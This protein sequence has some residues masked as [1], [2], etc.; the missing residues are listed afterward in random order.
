[1]GTRLSAVILIP[2]TAAYLML[3]QPLGVTLFQ[4]RS[5]THDEAMQT[6]TVIAVAAI[7]LVPFAISQMQLFAFYAMPDTKTPA[8]INMPVAALRDRC[9]TSLFY[10]VLPYAL[11]DGRPDDGE[12]ASRTCSRSS[13]ATCCCAGG[14]ACSGSTDDGRGARPARRSQRVIAAVPTWLLVH[15]AVSTCSAPARSASAITLVVGG[16]A[17]DRRSTSSPRS[18]LKATRRHRRG[19]DGEGPARPLIGQRLRDVEKIDRTIA[20]AAAV[21]PARSIDFAT[22]EPRIFSARLGSGFGSF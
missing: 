22:G 12:H 19:R 4:W 21:A 3:G 11:V 13:S 10:L 17:A 18:L 8:L 15:R 20:P 1:M 14:S 6:G 16:V 7:G 9:S 5:Y 2:A